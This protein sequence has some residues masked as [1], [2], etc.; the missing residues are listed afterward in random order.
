[1]TVKSLYPRQ[2]AENNPQEMV[3]PPEQGSHT[4]PAGSPDLF[5]NE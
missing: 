4:A 5:D 2:E 3:E 1:M